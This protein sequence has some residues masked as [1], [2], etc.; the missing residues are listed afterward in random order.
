MK[1]S[2]R[3]ETAM[4]EAIYSKE[5]DEGYDAYLSEKPCTNPYLDNAIGLRATEWWRT[6]EY[7]A[8]E[9]E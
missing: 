6:G 7:E 2:R 4:G 1:P 3:W 5:F 9:P 8:W